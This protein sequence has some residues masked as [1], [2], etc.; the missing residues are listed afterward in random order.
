VY[1]KVKNAG[2]ESGTESDTIEYVPLMPPVVRDDGVYT[3]STDHLHAWWM[4][5]DGAPDIAEYQYAIGTTPGGTDIV[6]WTSVS[7]D[8]E[9]TVTGLNLVDGQVYYFSV[10][11]RNAAGFWSDVATSNGI[12]VDSSLE[13][14]EL[15]LYPGWNFI[16][17]CLSVKDTNLPS[18]LDPIEGLY[19]SVWTYDANSK[20]WKRYVVGGPAFLND[21]TNMEHGKGYWIDMVHEAALPISG[22]QIVDVAIQ[23]LAGWN[24]TGYNSLTPQSREDALFSID[25]RYTSIWTY[26]SMTSQWLRYVVGGPAFLNNLNQLDPGRAYWIQIETDCTWTA[27]P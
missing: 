23:L 24:S 15:Y 13:Q 1:L 19:N 17:L 7:T 11:A 27:S 14:R 21:L 22:E 9:V 25:G 3:S 6:N 5:T 10:K 20:G 4:F 12:T 8:T 16:S 26:D 18:V 2:G